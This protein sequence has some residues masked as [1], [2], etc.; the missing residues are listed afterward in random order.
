MTPTRHV[1]EAYPIAATALAYQPQVEAEAEVLPFDAN[2][3]DD[4]AQR[5]LFSSPNEP[6]VIP[7]DQLTSP[8]ERESIRARASQIARQ[9]PVRSAKAEVSP[10]RP[11]RS[12]DKAESQQQF[13]FDETKFMPA[14]RSPIQCGAPVALP[15]LRFHAAL[16]DGFMILLSLVVFLF[17]FRFVVGALPTGKVAYCAYFACYVGLALAYKLLWCFAD[18]DSFGMK[19]AR[20][21]LVDLDG[22]RPSPPRRFW[23]ALSSFLSLGAVGLGLI[24]VF[25]DADHLAWHD[26][27][28]ATFPTFTEEK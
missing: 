28:S 16:V 25:A 11:R 2:A 9:A 5:V 27:I 10:R 17:L 20:L 8:A 6:R 24:W 23:R 21:R 19:A 15:L 3:T 12:T 4:S 1:R 13:Q 18:V 22:N 7:F 26:Q 14:P